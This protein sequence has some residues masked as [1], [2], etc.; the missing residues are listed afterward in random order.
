MMQREQNSGSPGSSGELEA[1]ARR[2]LD[3]KDGE[4]G[5]LAAEIE[6]ELHARLAPGLSRHFGRKLAEVGRDPGDADELAQRAWI[7]FWEALRERRYDPARARLSTFLYAVA[8]IVWM[9]DQRAKGRAGGREW[10]LDAAAGVAE[11]GAEPADAA[12]LAAR[13]DAVRRVLAGAE[14]ELSEQDRAVLRAI[15]EGAT[16]REVA[17]RM[18]I[19]AS[20]AH[21]RKRTAMERLAGVLR[22]LGFGDDSGRAP[23][24]GKA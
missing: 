22:S 19:S 4:V 21:Q 8:Q 14:G 2:L 18:G 16:D 24:G 10:A 20:T 23:G 17:A 11:V 13:L 15:G 7:A 3:A 5:A 12:D 1:I 6:T 9:R